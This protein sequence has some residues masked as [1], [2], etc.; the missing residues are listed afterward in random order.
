MPTA[1]RKPCST[2]GCPEMV[3]P[4]NGSKCEDHTAQADRIRGS[5][6]Q[7]GYGRKHRVRF[8]EGVLA[9][10]P[11][12]Q[13]CRVK[14]STDADHYPKSKRDLDKLGLDSN[15]PR[16]GRGLCHACHSKHTAQAQPGGWHAP[17]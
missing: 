8:R 2:V 5:S 1:P 9:K 10:H 7:R 12:C 4:G 14:A 13:L 3:T 17:F 11:I 15:D 16:Y 6:G